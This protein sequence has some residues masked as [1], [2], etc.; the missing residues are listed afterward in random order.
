MHPTPAQ[1]HRTSRGTGSDAAAGDLGRGQAIQGQLTRHCDQQTPHPAS[2]QPQ[3]SGRAEGEFL[4]C[5][6]APHVTHKAGYTVHWIYTTEKRKRDSRQREERLPRAE[7]KLGELMRQA[8]TPQS[9]RVPSKSVSALKRDTCASIMSAM[10]YH[11]VINPV[12][13]SERAFGTDWQRA[14]GQAHPIH[15]DPGTIYTLSWSRN[16]QALKVVSGE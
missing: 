16:Q 11:I 5:S 13:Q 9:S 14:P 4:L 12:Q 1:L 3:Y 6:T 15:H 10:F 2:T 8:R 7:R